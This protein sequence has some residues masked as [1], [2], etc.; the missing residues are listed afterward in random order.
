MKVLGMLLAA[1]PF[2]FASIRLFTTGNDMR[3][4]WMAVVSTLCAAAV[5]LG[6]GSPAAPSPARTGVA[7]I[8]AT[9][10]AAA[11]AIMLGAT[12]GSAI[13]IVAVAFGLCSALGTALVVRSRTRQTR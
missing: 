10:C 9:G 13:A 2:A 4:L 12:A 3:Y 6:P 7:T 1:V 11:A 5:L 8:A